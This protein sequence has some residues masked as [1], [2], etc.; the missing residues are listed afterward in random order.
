MPPVQIVLDTNVLIA[1]L[2]SQ[3]SALHRLLRLVDTGKF[4]INFSVPLV[5]EYEDA[6]KRLLNE[7]NL[8][9]QD[10]EDIIDYLLAR[11]N[12]HSIDYLWRPFLRDPNDDMVLELAV[13]A[14]CQAIVTFNVCDFAGAGQF[15]IRIMTPQ[16]LLRELGELP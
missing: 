9:N 6:A 16:M 11:G 14:G 7:T 8:S 5:L 4:E 1:A 12:R 3:R 2:R 15:G 10:V 13:A